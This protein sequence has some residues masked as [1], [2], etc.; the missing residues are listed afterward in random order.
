LQDRG[1]VR[2]EHLL[3]FADVQRHRHAYVVYTVGYERH[4]ET[5][6]RWAESHG[7][8]IHGRF[9]SFDYLNVDGC[10]LASLDLAAR[11]NGRPTSLD[12]IDLELVH[13]PT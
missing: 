8:H 13:V 7:V 1:L 6:R 3:V 9:G 11:L 2:P 4:V 12:E 5:V 10:V